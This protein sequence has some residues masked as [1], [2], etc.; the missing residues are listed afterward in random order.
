MS[1]QHL[2]KQAVLLVTNAFVEDEDG[3]HIDDYKVSFTYTDTE[4]DCTVIHSVEDLMAALEDYKDVGTV[5]IFARAQEKSP[6]FSVTH[7]K[8]ESNT[9]LESSETGKV[10]K[11]PR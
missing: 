6:T 4:G 3:V 1:L 5:K 9:E 10:R 8:D 7:D 2:K 11:L